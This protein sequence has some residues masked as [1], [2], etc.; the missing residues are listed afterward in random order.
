LDK[1]RII[2]GNFNRIN[3]IWVIGAV[4]FKLGYYWKDLGKL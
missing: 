3:E 4:S 1:I 2:W